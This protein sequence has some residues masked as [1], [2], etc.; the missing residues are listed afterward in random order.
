ML[1]VIFFHAGFNWFSGGFVGVDIF[2]VISGYLITSLLVEDIE[3]N[4]FSIIDFYERR[5]RRIL[6][7][8][9]FVILLSIPFA[10]NWMLPDQ[11]LGFSHSIVAVCLFI[12]NILFWQESDYFATASEE[13]PLLHT[14]SLAV[15]EQYYLLF[16]IFLA[17]VWRFGKKKVLGVIVIV[18][19]L[20][21][22]LCQWA[23]INTAGSANFYLAPSR[24]WELLAGSIAAFVVNRFGIQKN[25]VYSLL[26]LL[27]ILLSVFTYDE[28]VPFPSLYALV[29]VSG[30]VLVVLFASSTTF[31]ATML[32]NKLFVGVGLISYSAYLWHQPLFAFARV[33]SGDVPS[34]R[35]MLVLSFASIILAALTWKYVE[36][37][38]R[39]KKKISQKGIFLFS[40]I[41]GGFLVLIGA[42]G[43]VYAPEFEKYWLEGKPSTTQ[44]TYKLLKENIPHYDL[45]NNEKTSPSC[46]FNVRALNHKI[47]NKI[48]TCANQHGP[49]VLVLG[50]SHAMD[51]YGVIASRFNKPFLIGITQGGCRPHTISGDCYYDSVAKFLADNKKIFRKV[52]YEQAGFYLLKKKDGSKGAREMFSSLPMNA[53]VK[54]IVPDE[55]HILGTLQ[56][57]KKISIHTPVIWF[58]SRAEP[59]I[60][61]RYVLNHG[62]D[63]EFTFRTNQY[64]LFDSLDNR[65]ELEVSKVKLDNLRFV[66]QN[67]LFKFKMPDDFINCNTWYWHDG[68]HFS[69]DGEVYFGQR[70]PATFLD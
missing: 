5:A 40:S 46:R 29:P 53:V 70:L 54:G 20:S 36:Q 51:L 63:G 7:A 43:H 41:F 11:L 60:S 44:L 64:Q 24:A 39:N 38:F 16:P 65:I 2:F 21:L 28:L 9:F 31:V 17:L 10:L 57:L 66:S 47:E 62:C 22:L 56:Y 25:N 14:W 1:P 45:K 61:K 59:H 27:L 67:K 18:A 6:P 4:R 52:I 3:K 19:V 48:L 30:A 8:L 37:P 34:Q 23:S 33:H 69:K 15:E 68:D 35:L 32:S 49:G 13:K 26:G 58:G 50:D 55:V 12:S 42:S